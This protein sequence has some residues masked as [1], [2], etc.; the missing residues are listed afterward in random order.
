ME[1]GRLVRGVGGETVARPGFV[2]P[3]RLVPYVVG[4]SALVDAAK[5][6]RA[7]TRAAWLSNGGA[8]AM[9]AGLAIAVL[10]ERG[11]DPFERGSC[12]DGDA[13]HVTAAGLA[14]GGAVATLASIP[15]AR[16]AWRLQARAVWWS[17]ARFA[18]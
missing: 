18:P 6:D 13:L 1:G 14:V 17:N 9:V 2:S 16:Q 15:F 5:H 10:R 12:R 7:A 4:D 3:V 11:C 8:L